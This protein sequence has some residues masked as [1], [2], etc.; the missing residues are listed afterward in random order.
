MTDLFEYG[1]RNDR[2][3]HALKTSALG[4]RIDA[5]SQP[6]PRPTARPAAHASQAAAPPHALF[7]PFGALTADAV[8][9]AVVDRDA[10]GALTAA[11]VWQDAYVL[12]IQLTDVV[13]RRSSEHEAAE[14]VHDLQVGDIVIHDL[15]RGPRLVLDS[16]Y[17][18]FNI[19]IPRAAFDHVADQAK[20]GPFGDLDYQI[21]A[22]VRDETVLNIAHTLMPAL[23]LPHGA[24]RFLEQ[25]TLALVTHVVHAHGGPLRRDPLDRIGLAPW[26]R[27]RAKDALMGHLDGKICLKTVAQSCDL[28]LGHFSRAFRQSFGVPPYRFVLKARVE[29]AKALIRQH[30]HALA[31]I[32]L[33][34]GFADQSH[35]TR[36]FSREVGASPV[37]WRR[38]ALS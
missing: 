30:D 20:R 8:S 16:P 24:G 22:P 34:C 26:Q 37:A 18:A 32:A 28:S 15:R 19:H 6:R 7:G 31:D 38:T 14:A 25:L 36:V 29:A 13:Q 11:P 5:A 33:A 1:E 10:D 9:M 2:A 27:R 17:S 3:G 12:S 21:G 4:Q 23:R 35:M